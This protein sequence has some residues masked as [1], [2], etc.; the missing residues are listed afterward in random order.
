MEAKKS[1]V[2]LLPFHLNRVKRVFSSHSK[3]DIVSEP[4]VHAH[5]SPKNEHEHQVR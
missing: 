3:L 2:F 5:F 1:E 4:D